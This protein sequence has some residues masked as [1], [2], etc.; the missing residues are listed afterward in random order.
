[1]AALLKSGIDIGARNERARTNNGPCAYYGA[2]FVSLDVD[3]SYGLPFSVWL[4]LKCAA[5]S[6][7]ALRMRGNRAEDEGRNDG[8]N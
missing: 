2:A 3:G 5:G 1:M 6:R 7:S 8:R 4:F